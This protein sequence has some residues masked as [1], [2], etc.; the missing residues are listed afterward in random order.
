MSIKNIF[1]QAILLSVI[2]H[3]IIFSSFSFRMPLQSITQPPF[4]NFLGSFLTS[5]DTQTLIE[6]SLPVNIQRT[7]T[8]KV[9][10]RATKALPVKV[11]PQRSSSLQYRSSS[12]KKTLPVSKTAS[13]ATHMEQGK[14]ETF[15]PE[16]L[17]LPD[18]D[19]Y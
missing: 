13:S 8:L 2:F 4:V 5:Y 17:K 12:S 9:P 7:Q 19:R 10:T 18:Y 11:A 6:I 16:P 15:K 1:V 14:D 3:L